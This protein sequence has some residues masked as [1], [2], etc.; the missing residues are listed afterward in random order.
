[1]FITILII[2][3]ITKSINRLKVKLINIPIT[4]LINKLITELN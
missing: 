3:V 1:M 2:T 4:E